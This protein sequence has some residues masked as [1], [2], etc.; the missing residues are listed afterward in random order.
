MTTKKIKKVMPMTTNSIKPILP[1]IR[2]SPSW[3]KILSALFSGNGILTGYCCLALPAAVARR[4]TGPNLIIDIVR[5]NIDTFPFLLDSPCR[6]AVNTGITIITVLV[7]LFIRTGCNI[8]DPVRN[9]AAITPGASFLG[10]QGFAE[11]K[12]PK[13]AIKATCLS[14]QLLRLP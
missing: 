10:N 2:S 9:H 5:A 11:A 7:K 6:A 12:G 8:Q 1:N 3:T 13:P 14:D 4:I